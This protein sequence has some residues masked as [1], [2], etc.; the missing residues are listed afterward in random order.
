MAG[1][2]SSPSVVFTLESPQQQYWEHLTLAPTFFAKGHSSVNWKQSLDQ[3]QSVSNISFATL[4]AAFNP[5]TERDWVDDDKRRTFWQVLE[6]TIK[7]MASSYQQPRTREWRRRIRQ[8]SV[9]FDEEHRCRDRNKLQTCQRC[10]RKSERERER[11][12]E[13]IVLKFKEL[14]EKWEM[15]VSQ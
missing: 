7:E 12:K 4:P 9:C 8:Y 14:F 6:D 13:K 1:W 2:T 5:L 10:H 15:E 11:A 3:Q